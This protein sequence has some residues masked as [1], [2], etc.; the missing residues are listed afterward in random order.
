MDA[1]KKKQKTHVDLLTFLEIVFLK[2]EATREFCFDVPGSGGWHVCDL[3]E[4][5]GAEA[6]PYKLATVSVLLDVD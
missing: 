4:V 6:A 2:H 1:I 3:N 5:A